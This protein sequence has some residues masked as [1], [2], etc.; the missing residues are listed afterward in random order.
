M[1]CSFIRPD[2]ADGLLT[3]LTDRIDAAL[4]KAAPNLKVISNY[5]V[6]YDNVDLVEAGKRG[7][8]VGNTPNVLTETTADMAFAL[9]MASARRLVEGHEYTMKG[10]WKTWGPRSSWGRIF[11]GLHWG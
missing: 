5:A 9:L 1:T 3:L 7:I 2:Q 6:G 4:M 11:M 8:V 10:L